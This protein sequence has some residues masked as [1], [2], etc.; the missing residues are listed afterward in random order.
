MRL[1]IAAELPPALR[2]ALAET[3]AALRASVRGRYVGPNLFH[4]TLA[5]LGDV[6]QARIPDIESALDAACSDHAPLEV[7][8]GE[9]GSF[10]K[11]NRATLWQ[12]LSPANELGK[13]A[14]DVRAELSRA[15][16]TFDGKPFKP[17][18]T[19]MRNADLTSG[20]LPMPAQAQGEIRIV[21]LF[22]SDLSGPHPVYTPLYRIEL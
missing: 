9:L 14:L 13:L 8:L 22:K 21:T 19:P 7:A 2:D 5:F 4:V 3:S 20:N 16:F 11:R 6:E 12:G 17:H 10:G 1:F 15:D 18:I